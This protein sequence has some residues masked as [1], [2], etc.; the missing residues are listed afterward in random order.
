MRIEPPIA[1]ED[2]PA[3]VLEAANEDPSGPMTVAQYFRGGETHQRMSLVF[4]WLVREGS[5]SMDHPLFCCGLTRA[6]SDH[7]IKRRLGML[8]PSPIDVVLDEAKR[9]IVQ[10][11]ATV[12][13]RDRY[14]YIRNKRLYG[15]PNIAIEV[16]SPSTAKRD[17][18]VKLAWYRDYG[19]HEYWIVDVRKKQIDVFDL[20]AQP[21]P[22][23]TK[24]CDGD[25]LRSR[26]L[27]HFACSV[28]KVFE[29]AY[30]YAYPPDTTQ[31][32]KKVGY[33]R[34]LPRRKR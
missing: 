21:E 15:P 24:F 3:A 7:I 30:D 27:P 31:E 14:H 19:V 17:R 12:L 32:P 4:G 6:L 5:P 16:R 23:I 1:I 10:P 8:L 28:T 26:V 11:D 34:K 22:I 29:P 9:L 13:L 25:T 20:S 2:I 18:T 33:A